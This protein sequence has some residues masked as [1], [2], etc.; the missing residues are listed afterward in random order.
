T[1]AGVRR[2]TAC[3]DENPLH[4][5]HTGQKLPC[6][7]RPVPC[8]AAYARRAA[9]PR[10]SPPIPDQSVAK[11]RMPTLAAPTTTLA[12]IRTFVRT[13]FACPSSNALRVGCASKS[14]RALFV[15][16]ADQTATPPSAS[17]TPPRAIPTKGG[18]PL[19][20]LGASLDEG[21]GAPADAAPGGGGA[22]GG[23]GEA[24]AASGFE[25]FTSRR[26]CA[27]PSTRSDVLDPSA[28]RPTRV[29]GPGS[30]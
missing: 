18:R 22:G 5:R 20:D 21:A 2:E 3:R 27:A 13:S 24:G 8:E 14:S 29:C 6:R 19:D 16:S 25:S 26:W 17:A 30:R 15:S 7:A 23:A 4:R 9:W 28:K 10:R 12:A 11:V 1:G